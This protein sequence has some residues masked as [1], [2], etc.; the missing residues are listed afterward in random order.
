MIPARTGDTMVEAI[1]LSSP[2]G[3]MSKRAR[4]AA[5]RRLSESLFGPG[6]LT[7]EQC[8]GPVRQPTKLEQAAKLR[9]Y[10]RMAGPRQAKKLLAQAEVLER[11]Q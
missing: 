2:S 4:A 1:A 9:E 7:R 10:A 8:M 11:I 5:E 3:R 6:G